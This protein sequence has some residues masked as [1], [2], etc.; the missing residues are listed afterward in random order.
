ME[1]IKIDN[2]DFDF[3]YSALVRNFPEEERRDY[4]DASSIIENPA[5]SLFHIL[6]DGK[7]VGFISAWQLDKICFIEHFVIYESY[8]SQ[9]LGA[10]ALSLFKQKFDCIVLEVEPPVGDIQKRRIGF[11]E[12]CG[13]KA[14][15]VLYLQPSYRAN[16]KAVPLV[17]MSYPA[18]LSDTEAA[19]KEIYKTVYNKIHT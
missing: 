9:G 11:Y 18:P 10:M 15:S 17:L 6:S 8:R 12:R 4:D 14:N 19:I 3:I 7:R 1:L 16:G 13:F 2:S 5:Y